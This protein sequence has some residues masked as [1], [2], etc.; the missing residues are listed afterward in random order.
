MNRILISLTPKIPL[1]K[2]L[3]KGH[4]SLASFPHRVQRAE[5]PGRRASAVHAINTRLLGR[6]GPCD[7]YSSECLFVF[8][9]GTW[10]A[11]FGASFAQR[12]LSHRRRICMHLSLCN[13][14]QPD[15]Q[16]FYFNFKILANYQEGG[17]LPG[18]SSPISVTASASLLPAY[19]R[20]LAEPSCWVDAISP[21][22][23]IMGIFFFQNKF[24]LFLV[25]VCLSHVQLI[26]LCFWDKGYL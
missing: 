23:L 26:S 5:N 8:K 20:R 14:G 9:R 4:K 24:S 13:L 15:E 25:F 10:R 1:S 12:R 16:Y 6:E 2:P 17:S 18:I 19:L 11:S 3:R 21:G 22:I 7:C